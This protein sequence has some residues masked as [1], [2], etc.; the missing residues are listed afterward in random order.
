MPGRYEEGSPPTQEDYTGHVKDNSTQL[1]YA[2]ARYYSSAFGRWTTTDPLADKN[3]ADSPYAYAVNNPLRYVDPTGRDTTVE[4][5]SGDQLTIEGEGGLA[6]DAGRGGRY[7]RSTGQFSVKQ[8]L[9]RWR[10]LR[11]ENGLCGESGRFWGFG[12]GIFIWH[13]QETEWHII[14]SQPA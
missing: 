9:R 10:V 13:I 7:G 6:L 5:E 4:T 14:I 12:W 1:H 11:R 2:G 8:C 3:F